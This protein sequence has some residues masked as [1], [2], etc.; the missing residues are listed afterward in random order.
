[1]DDLTMSPNDIMHPGELVEGSLQPYVKK[2]VCPCCGSA[3]VWFKPESREYTPPFGETVRYEVLMQ[4]CTAC[5]EVFLYEDSPDP[6]RVSAILQHADQ[7]TVPIMLDRLEAVGI[8]QQ[9]IKRVLGLG[10]F[11]TNWRLGATQTVIALLRILTTYPWILHV[12]DNKFDSKVAE[13]FAVAYCV[14][15][16]EKEERAAEPS[17]TVSEMDLAVEIGQPT[18]VANRGV[19]DYQPPKNTKA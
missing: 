4:H 5:I 17:I 9:S 14:G 2:A 6:K 18:V 1:M 11:Q 10:D 7:A 3:D 19:L 15:S 12:A 8:T 16:K 13:K